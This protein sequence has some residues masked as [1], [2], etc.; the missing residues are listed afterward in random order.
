MDLSIIVPVYNEEVIMEEKVRAIVDFFSTRR[1]TW[2][3]IIVDDGSGD[4]TRRLL[5]ACKEKYPQLNVIS[6]THRG[7]GAAVREGFLRGTGDWLLFFDVDLSTPLIMFDAFWAKRNERKVLIGSR[8]LPDAHVKTHQWWLKERVGKFGNTLTR[9]LL[10]IPFRDTQCGFK[11][12]PGSFRQLLPL[13]VTNGA[14]FDIEWLL[15]AANNGYDV[16]EIPVEWTNRVESK[17]G[18]GEYLKAIYELGKVVA[19]QRKGKY[20][21]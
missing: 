10:P 7:K 1:L 17:F 8:A 6:I 12:Y 18:M 14:A 19:M 20:I 21:K 4:G 2:E 9:I 13:S 15:I 5:E 11:M 3:F 16:E